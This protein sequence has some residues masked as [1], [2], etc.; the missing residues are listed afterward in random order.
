MSVIIHPTAIVAPGAELNENVEIG[1]YSIIGENVKITRGTKVGPHVLIEG[2]T[3]IG[4]NCQ[5]FQGAVIGTPAQDVSSQRKRSYVQIG[6]NNL[7]REYV[8]IHRGT[9]EESTTYVGNS[10]FLMAYSHIAHNCRIG[11][12][13]VIANCG[14]LAGYVTVEKNAV[15]GGLTA[16][17]QF[18]RIGAYAIIGG[19]SK[20]V[21]DIPPYIK[22][23]GHPGTLWGLNTVGLRRAGFSLSRRNLLKKAYRI[24]FRSHLNTSQALE[25]IEKKLDLS[26][27]IDHLCEFIRTSQR[28][29]C[30]ERKKVV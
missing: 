25:E 20:I 14:S 18:V 30:K 26:P 5:I 23:T 2:W 12:E 4:E 15:I 27:E 9:K 6:H 7:I 19:C 13:V 21:Q 10:T 1:P 16:I 3:Q 8:T 24:L 22:A 29:I 11:D 17:H 28:G